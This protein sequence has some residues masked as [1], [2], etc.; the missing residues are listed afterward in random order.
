MLHAIE[1][2]AVLLLMALGQGVLDISPRPARRVVASFLAWAL[3]FAVGIVVLSIPAVAGSAV[4]LAIVVL[5]AYMLRWLIGS[6]VEYFRGPYLLE[7]L[8]TGE[9]AAAAEHVS[10]LP[11]P[12]IRRITRRMER[13]YEGF[14]CLAALLRLP[15]GE[16][17]EERAFEQRWREGC[18][19]VRKEAVEMAARFGHPRAEGRFNASAVMFVAQALCV[20]EPDSV[21]RSLARLPAGALARRSGRAKA[22]HQLNRSARRNAAAERLGIT[23]PAAGEEMPARPSPLTLAAIALP[24]LGIYRIGYKGRAWAFAFAHATLFLYGAAALSMG[25]GAGYVF[26]GVGLMLHIQALLGLGD[27]AGLAEE[28]AHI[29]ATGEMQR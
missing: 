27:F 16:A 1:L 20:F 15:L 10:G 23:T 24:A 5:A 21:E 14:L 22:V 11:T 19:A 12:V 9:L 7:P 28:E 18:E 8:R 17:V 4:R 29:A 6:V 2:L 26:L 3:A 25:R 13:E